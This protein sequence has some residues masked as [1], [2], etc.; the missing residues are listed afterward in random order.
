MRKSYR[1]ESRDQQILIEKVVW[2][3]L[4]LVARIVV[5]GYQYNGERPAQPYNHQRRGGPNIYTIDGQRE[6][7]DFKSFPGLRWGLAVMNHQ[8]NLQES[9]ELRLSLP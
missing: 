3:K 1:K 7:G 6:K 4:Y 8:Q 9:T 2:L 5:V